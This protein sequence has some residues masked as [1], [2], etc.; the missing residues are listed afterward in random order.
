MI[1]QINTAQDVVTFIEEIANEIADFNPFE[2]FRSYKNP[3]NKEHRY[4]EEE[5]TLRDQLMERCFEVCKGQSQNFICLAIVVFQEAR[6]Y[7]NCYN[8]QQI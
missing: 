4:T 2:Q 1:E 8:K 7:P 6:D 3:E 5:A